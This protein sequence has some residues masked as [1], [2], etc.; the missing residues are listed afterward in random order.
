MINI[1]Q[2][3]FL[4]FGTVLCSGSSHNTLC[5]SE[6]DMVL[7]S[8]GA[9]TMG[10]K[11]GRDSTCFNDEKPAHRVTL[12]DFYIGRYE[13]TNAE[14]CRFL[15]EKGNQSEGGA[16]W[17]NL[18]GRFNDEKCRISKN[19]NLF[20]VDTG[21]ENH[22]VIYVSWY[23]AAAYCAWLSQQTGQNYRLPTEGEWEFAAR[24]GIET[25]NYLYA[26]SN[27]LDEVA[28]HRVN[29]NGQTQAV[30]TKKANEL[31][32]FDLSGNVWEWCAD[33]WHNEYK[34]APTNENAWIEHPDRGAN[35]VIRG[36]GWNF[37]P[38]RCRAAVRYYAGPQS[39]S[40]DVGFRIA[41]QD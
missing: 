19:G 35:R 10:C 4:L 30:G 28:W 7:V 37:E 17:I 8:G 12:R 24:G 18:E 15:N 29:S 39:R 9:F 25:R 22:P 41:R 1:T 26:G 13:V 27:T 31:D 32:L 34:G 14:Y 2:L 16:D 38:K 5:V 36:G 40:S 3:F 23:G 33:D 11:G 21:Y 20:T 6:P